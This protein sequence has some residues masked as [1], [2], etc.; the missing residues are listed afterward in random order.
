MT[1]NIG[2]TCCTHGTDKELI[3]N[4]IGKFTRNIIPGRPWHRWENYIKIEDY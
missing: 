3:K 4:L 2:G 1:I